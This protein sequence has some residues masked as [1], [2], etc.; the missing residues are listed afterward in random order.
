MARRYTLNAPAAGICLA[1]PA[2]VTVVL[3]PGTDETSGRH[4]LVREYLLVACAVVLSLTAL[5]ILARSEPGD[6]PW[7]M[8][9][10]LLASTWAC[11]LARPARRA[12][13]AELVEL[14]EPLR[15]RTPARPGQIHRLVWDAAS[16]LA[17]ASRP[18]PPPHPSQVRQVARIRTQLDALVREAPGLAAQ[19]RFRR[20]GPTTTRLLVTPRHH[21]VVT[22]GGVPLGYGPSD[23]HPRTASTP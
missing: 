2:A 1:W 12:V 4:N 3:D 17:Q 6:R 20:V 18:G 10:G 22:S 8:T 16:L 7:E 11:H 15:T 14:L 21:R 5:A 9:G 19:H 13:P 23:G